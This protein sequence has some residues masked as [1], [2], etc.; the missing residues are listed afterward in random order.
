M[1]W[2]MAAMIQSAHNAVNVL[3]FQVTW[4]AVV[5]GAAGGSLWAGMTALGL[6]AAH[7]LVATRRWQRDLGAAAVCVVV[8]GC[9]DTLWIQMGILDLGIAVAPPWILMLWAAVGLSVHASLS[10]FL[11]RPLLGGLSAACAAPLSYSAGAG[12][13]A[14]VVAAPFGLA[15]IS[16]SWLMLFWALFSIYGAGRRLHLEFET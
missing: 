15:I 13:G 14:A 8:G 11:E 3:L 10:W 1:T 5:F 16:A 9:L 2:M 7:V 12:I 6:L 4:F